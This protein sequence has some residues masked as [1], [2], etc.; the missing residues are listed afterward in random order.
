MTSSSDEQIPDFELGI[1]APVG[2]A[3]RG[4]SWAQQAEPTL[5]RIAFATRVGRSAD[6]AALVRH[7]VVEAAEIHELYTTWCIAIPGI[8]RRDGLGD[9]RIAQLRA[10]LIERA[11]LAMR[12]S[13]RPGSF[14]LGRG[15][16]SRSY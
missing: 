12:T 14:W 4:G 3:V 7:L 16:R 15:A 2:R 8:L 10:E 5:G 9:E 11:A 1:W 13:M 6:A